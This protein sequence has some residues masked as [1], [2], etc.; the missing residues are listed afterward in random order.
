MV[1]VDGM[2]RM[3]VGGVEEEDMEDEGEAVI[4][5]AVVVGLEVGE[6]EGGGEEYHLEVFTKHSVAL[7]EAGKLLYLFTG[8]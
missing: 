6:E 7:W 2:A 1:A 4:E 8:G 3:M 5:E